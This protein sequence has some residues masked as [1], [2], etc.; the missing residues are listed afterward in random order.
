MLMGSWTNKST[1]VVVGWPNTLNAVGLVSGWV[2][3]VDFL[4]QTLLIGGT[5]LPLLELT[6]V[7][8]KFRYRSLT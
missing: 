8:F 7:R 4:T 1:E 6:R 2:D 5:I 3:M